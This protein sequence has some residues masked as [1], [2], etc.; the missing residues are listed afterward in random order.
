M[1]WAFVVVALVVRVRIGVLT[2]D[3]IGPDV[4]EEGWKKDEP[5]RDL[6][7]SELYC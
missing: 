7:L 6:R 1:I 2:D 5:K 3:G 4:P